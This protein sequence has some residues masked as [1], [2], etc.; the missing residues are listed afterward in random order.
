MTTHDGPLSDEERVRPMSWP[1]T[2]ESVGRRRNAATLADRVRAAT[3]TT[4]PAPEP[5]PAPR[6][7]PG[8]A[9][10][11]PAAPGPTTGPKGR[12]TP[13]P[14]TRRGPITVPRTT[15]PTGPGSGPP[16]GLLDRIDATL[17]A[18]DSGGGTGS[19]VRF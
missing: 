8:A 3:P 2:H 1:L 5:T 12:E 7:A 16:P 4:A 18:A 17:D 19:T 11:S 14:A 10:A 6:K 15:R 9:K 13:T